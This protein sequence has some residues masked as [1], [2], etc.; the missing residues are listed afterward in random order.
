MSILRDKTYSDNKRTLLNFHRAEI[1]R[2]LPEH[3]IQ[4][5][6]TLKTLFSKYYEWLDSSDNFGGQIQELYSNRD[7][8]QVPSKL[9]QYLEDEL[10]LGQA[11]FGG[12]LNKR[13]AIKFSNLLYRSKGT[14]YST[15][16]FF[17]GFFG[18]DP[19]VEYPK[20]NIFLVG[21]QIDYDLDSVNNAG[22]QIKRAAAEIGPESRKYIT[23]DKLYQV[24]SVLIKSSLPL[25]E[26]KDVYKLFVH[27]AGVYLA[28]ETLIE[29]T[30]VS[31]N[32]V[33][34]NPELVNN[35]GINFIMDEIGDSLGQLLIVEGA[36][37]YQS[38]AFAEITL[39]NKDDGSVGM[40]RQ[41]TDQTFHDVGSQSID[42][43]GTGY[44]LDELLSPNSVT[45]DDSDSR[46]FN[47]TDAVQFSQHDD[48]S[49]VLGISTFDRHEFSTLFDSSNIADSAHWPFR[50]V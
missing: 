38:E 15:Q 7:A 8:T 32:N 46:T 13:E 19:I 22:Q 11:Y 40:R 14:K 16:Q 12:F 25:N 3:V 6:P 30:N 26:W 36:N 4:D 34:H 39:I 24:L 45:F 29:M 17:R 35:G 50:H 23:D 18:I 28:G 47:V 20:N 33:A 44:T 5:N 48:S 21:P 2:V 37:V 9:L 41:R 43:L 49:N 1:D 42:S 31:W 27:P 10:L